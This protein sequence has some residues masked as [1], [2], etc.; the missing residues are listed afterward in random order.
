MMGKRERDQAHL[1]PVKLIHDGCVQPSRAFVTLELSLVLENRRKRTR[2]EAEK[3]DVGSRSLAHGLGG[4][5]AYSCE[6]FTHSESSK[7]R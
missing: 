2:G 5:I 1:K 6:C 4:S 7:S 3:L